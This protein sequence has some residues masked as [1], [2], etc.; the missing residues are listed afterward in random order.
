LCWR[1]CWCRGALRRHGADRAQSNWLF[2]ITERQGGAL[3]RGRA[4][5]ALA[6]GLVPAVALVPLHVA[7]WGWSTAAYHLVVGACYA[8]FIVELLFNVQVKV[9]FAAAYL[10]GSIRLKTRW[11]LYLFA[12][13]VLTS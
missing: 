7:M 3:S 10:S 13:S 12:A 1:C 2:R 6:I 11:L 9:P 5:G 4:V 8:V